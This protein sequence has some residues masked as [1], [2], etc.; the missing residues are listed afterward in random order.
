VQPVTPTAEPGK[1]RWTRDEYYRMAD[2]GW[3]DGQ[4]VE[5]IDGEIMVQS[6]QK[7]GHYAAVDRTAEVLR[8]AFGA[9]YWVRTQAPMGFG[10]FSEPE[11]DVSVVAGRREDFTDHPTTAALLVEVSDTTLA[12][13]R[14]RKASLYACVGIPE[15]WIVNLVNR[16]LEVHRDSAPD[17]AQDFGHG[18][19]TRQVLTAPATL[20]PLALPA[21]A[22]PV[23]DLIP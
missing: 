6:P 11:P 8:A 1:R 17:N 20:A 3:F 22:I 4:R 16:Q 18:Y 5:L 14:Q 9:G 7:F 10:A 13:D 2:L 19:A 15:Y 12:Y 23:A 21:V